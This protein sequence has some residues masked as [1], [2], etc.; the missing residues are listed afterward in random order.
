M[1]S[2]TYCLLAWTWH[3]DNGCFPKSQS[4]RS[5]AWAKSVM[6]A[7]QMEIWVYL[8]FKNVFFKS[9]WNSLF[10][11][12]QLCEGSWLLKRC[13]DIIKTPYS[14][15]QKTTNLSVRPRWLGKKCLKSLPKLWALFSHEKSKK[16]PAPSDPDLT[17]E[18]TSA[19]IFRPY[20]LSK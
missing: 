1:L 16:Q 9:I 15:R 20:L 5:Q 2:I 13:C 18:E 19:T 3:S 11:N 8:W 6:K 12:E 17:L 4:W 14:K 10:W 7:Y